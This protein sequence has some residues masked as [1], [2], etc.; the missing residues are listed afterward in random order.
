MREEPELNGPIATLPLVRTRRGRTPW[1]ERGAC[2]RYRAVGLAWLAQS[3]LATGV[4]FAQAEPAVPGGGAEHPSIMQVEPGLMIWTIVTFIALLVLLRFTAWGPLQK[5]LDAREKRIR[6][7]VEGAERARRDSEELL[8]RHRKMIDDATQEAAKIID[9]GKADGLRL[10]HELNHQARAEAEEMRTRVRRE[11]DLATDQAKKE[12]W[13][14]ATQLSTE[15]AER[16]LE[17]TLNSADEGRLIA[18]VVKDYRS[19]G[20]KAGN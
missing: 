17:R 15:L 5:S 11:L 16:I 19:V 18:Q 2:G 4:A 13:D 10:K 7:A 12:L 9:E 14:H 1:R 6:D 3:G 20:A 8:E